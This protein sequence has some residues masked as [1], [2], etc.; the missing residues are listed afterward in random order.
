MVAQKK[1]PKERKIYRQLEMKCLH[2][3]FNKDIILSRAWK[4]Q[5]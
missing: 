3:F 5:I 4:L 2:S 1:N